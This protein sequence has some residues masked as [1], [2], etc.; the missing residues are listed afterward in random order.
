MWV[1]VIVIKGNS[2]TALV[3]VLHLCI[4][5]YLKSALR[6]KFSILGTYRTDTVFPWT[7]MWGSMVI[8][9]SHNGPTN[10]RFGKHWLRACLCYGILRLP[11][12]SSEKE[13]HKCAWCSW[14]WISQSILVHNSAPQQEDI[15]QSDHV[16]PCILNLKTRWRH[17]MNVTSCPL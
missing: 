13:I 5:I 14:A 1:T 3:C 10:K 12:P 2:C 15:W 6:Y 8:F 7:R 4:S 16:S 17:M 11:T 9:W